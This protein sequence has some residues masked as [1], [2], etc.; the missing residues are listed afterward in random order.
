[1]IELELLVN[2][3]RLV[4][5]CLYFALLLTRGSQKIHLRE[6]ITPC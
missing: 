6:Q 1:M 3:F 5:A 2:T 4:S